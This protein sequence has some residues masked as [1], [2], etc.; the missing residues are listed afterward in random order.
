VPGECDDAVRLEERDEVHGER[1]AYLGPEWLGPAVVAGGLEP[2]PVDTRAH[3]PAVE[4]GRD[5]HGPEADGQPAP[6]E[7]RGGRGVGRWDAARM[8]AAAASTFVASGPTCGSRSWT[9]VRASPSASRAETIAWR[10]SGEY[11][12]VVT[13]S[14][15]LVTE[16]TNA[17][18]STLLS[19]SR[20]FWT[21]T[22]ACSSAVGS[23]GISRPLSAGS[24]STTGVPGKRSRPR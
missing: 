24:A 6:R 13:P 19:R 8:S 17:S 10:R 22:C 14:T 11:T 15:A 12:S 5:V 9:R 21:F 2:V 23:V 3:L 18:R 7:R 4:E 16:R 1:A 20:I